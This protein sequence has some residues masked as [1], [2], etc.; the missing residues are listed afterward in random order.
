MLQGVAD[1]EECMWEDCDGREE[2]IN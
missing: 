2:K 1:E